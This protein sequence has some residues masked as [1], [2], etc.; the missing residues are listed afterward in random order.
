MRDSMKLFVDVNVFIDIQRK[1][2][3]W[4]ESFIVVKSV[5][6]GENEGYISALTPTIIY[7]LRRQITSEK[8]ARQETLD[9]IEGFNI[10]NLTSELIN[11]ALKEKR[12][13]DFEDAIQF[14]SAKNIAKTF[15]TRNKRD[16]K[17]VKDEIQVLTPEEFTEKYKGLII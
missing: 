11:M 10:V 16:Y 17:N 1:R 15:V 13:E 12:I 6:E 8:R 7:F 4:K 3:G 14:H 5:M 2:D 9:A